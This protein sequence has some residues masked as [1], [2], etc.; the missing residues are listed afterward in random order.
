MID[1]FL[2]LQVKL[3]SA[4]DLGGG[5]RQQFSVVPAAVQH[6]AGTRLLGITQVIGL[7][8]FGGLQQLEMRDHREGQSCESD[9]QRYWTHYDVHSHLLWHWSNNIGGRIAGKWRYPRQLFSEIS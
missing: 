6:A 4:G 9:C 2:N 1:R 7:D 5:V 3:R 8:P